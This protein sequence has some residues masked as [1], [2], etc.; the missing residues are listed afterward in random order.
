M[1]DSTICLNFICKDN[2]KTIEHMIMSA[3]PI[4]DEV[5]ACDTGSIDGTLELLIKLKKKFE[6]EFN[7]DFYILKDEWKNFGHNRTLMSKHAYENAKSDYIMIV[8]TDAWVELAENFNKK[9]THD[10]Y[11]LNW[12]F[13]STLINLPLVLKNNKAWKWNNYAHNV[14]DTS[15]SISG[16]TLEGI[17]VKEDGRNVKEEQKHL[18]RTYNLLKQQIKDGNS[19]SRTNFY[20][21]RVSTGIDPTEATKYFYKVVNG[22]N[23]LEE[24]YISY[25]DLANLEPA[26]KIEHLL[27]AYEI[28]PLRA[29]ALYYLGH[30]YRSNQKYHLAEF[31]LRKSI[32]MKHSDKMLFI[33]V[34]IYTYLRYF[35]LSIALY[36]VGKFKEAFKFANK[37]KKLKLSGGI[38]EQNEKN[39]VFMKNKL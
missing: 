22:D 10:Y 13:A 38:D 33:N 18:K 19:T 23:W 15:G 34:N 21:A 7:K 35:E 2:I 14:L 3:E 30:H 8:D 5:V 37:V 24:K 9:F 36:W 26:K 28:N 16:G 6:T 25:C 1:K 17:L 31:F 20:F 29:E 27:N 4:I 12:H 11:S 32:N 39:L